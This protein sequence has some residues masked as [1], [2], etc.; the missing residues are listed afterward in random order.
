MAQCPLVLG[1]PLHLLARDVLGHLVLC[2]H[3]P[4]DIQE[5][6]RVSGERRLLHQQKATL[7]KSIIKV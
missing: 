6:E 5:H 7:I 4:Y 2:H 1:H 3:E